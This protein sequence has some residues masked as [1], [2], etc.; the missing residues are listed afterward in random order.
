M[1]SESL[2]AYGA[3]RGGGEVTRVTLG[4]VGTKAVEFAAVM[5]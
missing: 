1:R 3:S 4:V 2:S 5:N